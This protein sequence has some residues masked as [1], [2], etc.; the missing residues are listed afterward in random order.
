MVLT[1]W[2]PLNFSVMNWYENLVNLIF[3]GDQF[4]ANYER[5]CT[6]LGKI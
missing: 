4:R 5:I 2:L 1:P 6:L 3:Y